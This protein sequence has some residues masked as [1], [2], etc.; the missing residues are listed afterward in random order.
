MSPEPTPHYDV[1]TFLPT[2]PEEVQA[3]GWDAVDVVFVS[4][5]AYVDHPSFAM[6]L[7][8]RL[9]ESEGYRVAILSQPD[10][11][12]CDPWR[13]F[14][15]PR[16][17]FAISAGNMDSMLNHYT[18][19]RK[20]RNDDAYSPGGQIGRRPDRATL[21]Y[22]Q[23]AREAFKGVP[24][25][26][27]GV[28]A[29]LRRLTHYDYWSDKV[30]RSM[31]LD[32]KA[33]LI[34][35]GMGERAL[36]E[37]AARLKA[38][39][40]LP[41]L[42]DI[43][44]VVYRL[45]ASETPPTDDTIR[46]PSHEEVIADRRAF[47]AMTRIAHLETNPYNAKRLVQTHG[48]EAVVINP[49]AIPLAEE[50]M[51][52]VYGLPYT[53][54]PHPSYGE[55]RIPAFEVVKDSIQ[56]MRGCF[57]GCTFCSITTHEGR[58]IQSRSR[59]SVLA[60]I[61]RLAEDPR[62]KGVISDIGGPTANMYRMNCSQPEVRKKCRRLSCVHP[63]ICKLLDT[64]HGP[65]IDLMRSARKQ[66]GIKKVHVASGI[67]MD[68]AQRDG[69][70]LRELAEHHVGGLLKVAPEHA[71][72]E[73]L[74]LMKKPSIDDFTAFDEKFRQASA[75]AGKKQHLVPYFIA[76]H[77][78]SDLHSMIALAQFLKRTGFRPD[79]VQDFIASPM[80]IATCMYY[81]GIE[82]IS[83]EEVYVARSMRERKLQRALLQFF[84]PENYFDV[85]EALMEAARD[86]LIG[87]GPE[88][89][90]KARPPRSLQK[91]EPRRRRAAPEGFSA[92][93]PCSPQPV[94]GYR[95]YRKSAQRRER[96]G[97]KG[98]G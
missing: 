40:T 49:P 3:R 38:G 81:T 10:W 18:A 15:R 69:N 78:G 31:I 86:D 65:L 48:R 44:G 90:I 17:C 26:A 98:G 68:L 16:I 12:T 9:L 51:D 32:A 1:S 29:S 74:R 45:G 93:L 89:L 6:A 87:D 62:F 34:C 8:G 77:P 22:C 50:E 59:E 82:P 58:I 84:K 11:H 53:R 85:R 83:G 75:A 13:A 27:G 71:D 56:I 19:S 80:D 21:V 41:Q 97:N 61:R 52:R 94:A 54:L 30:R 25:I 57:G 60:E 28:E 66:E 96:G 72:P 76:G 92:A 67:R 43:R 70:Y 33:D 88:C 14:G 37:I 42:R 4:G 36:L 20:V 55:Q 2:T 79:K 23:R 7:L 73:V 46:L 47:A 64:D 39:Q 63:T 24:V 95:P 5:D 91:E 35:F